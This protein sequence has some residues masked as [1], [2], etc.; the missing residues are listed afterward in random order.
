MPELEDLIIKF[1]RELTKQK[2]L[3]ITLDTRFKE[4]LRFDSLSTTELILACEEEFGIEIDI[5]HPDTA[6]AKT[7][8][9]LYIAVKQLVNS[10]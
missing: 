1:A 9:D 2:N 7:L 3:E 8:R 10:N 4:D 5:E 6:K